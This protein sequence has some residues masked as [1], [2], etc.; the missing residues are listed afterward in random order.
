MLAEGLDK[1]TRTL[2]NI[3]PN[4]LR[5]LSEAERDRLEGLL[6]ER[7][8]AFQDTTI[9]HL[10]VHHGTRGWASTLTHVQYFTEIYEIVG[11]EEFKRLYRLS[12]VR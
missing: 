2:A 7:S 9:H 10:G 8:I 4:I 12:K 5:R 11:A 6:S 3:H 1:F